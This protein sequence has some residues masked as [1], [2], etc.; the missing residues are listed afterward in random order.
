MEVA[1]A[2]V[3][4]KV[5]SCN[6]QLLLSEGSAHKRKAEGDFIRGFVYSVN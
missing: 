3:D 5:K 2:G 1:S 6:G 4:G